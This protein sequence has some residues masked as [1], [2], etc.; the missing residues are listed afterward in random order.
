[1]NAK[2]GLVLILTLVASSAFAHGITDPTRPPWL[3]AQAGFSAQEGE[4]LRAIV[5]GGPR[6]LALI[7]GR[8]L[9]VGARIGRNHI[10]AIYRDVV[11]LAGP[12]GEHRLFLGTRSPHIKKAIILSEESR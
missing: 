11:I 2:R 8:L 4:G 6:R 1:M 10:V 3:G 7:D 9:G 12:R 5:F